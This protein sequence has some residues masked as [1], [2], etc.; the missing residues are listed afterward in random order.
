M[1]TAARTA[2]ESERL[3]LGMGLNDA[4]VALELPPAIKDQPLRLLARISQAAALA[5]CGAEVI[6][7]PSCAG[8]GDSRPL[9]S[10]N[11]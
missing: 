5:S 3:D 2:G 11:I 7:P 4:L 9:N 8:A 6:V 1:L 10:A